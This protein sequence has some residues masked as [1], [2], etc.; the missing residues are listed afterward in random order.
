MGLCRL[1]RILH[2]SSSIL[3]LFFLVVLVYVDDVLIASN[4]LNQIQTVKN[5][6]HDA[7]K[8]KVLGKAK[9]FLGLEIL[10]SSVGINLCQRK[11]TLD[12]LRDSSFLGYKLSFTPMVPS[13]KLTKHTS[14]SLKILLCTNSL[15]VDCFTL[16]N[17]RLDISYYVQNLSQ[18][19]DTPTQE[20]LQA[21]HQVLQYLKGTPGQGF[22]YP[23]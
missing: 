16:T 5:F 6:L 17:T 1:I 10:R 18:F 21:A 22:F 8:I 19:L 2:F 3:I 9:Y 23:V 20:H 15:L 12:L 4:D 11:Y 7:F 13:I 14:V